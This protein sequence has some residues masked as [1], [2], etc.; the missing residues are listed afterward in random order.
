MA[1][2][3]TTALGDD[4]DDTLERA[5]HQALTEFYERHLPVLG[6]TTIVLLPIRNEGNA[7][8]SERVTAIGDPESPT[9][10]AGWA[11]TARYTQHVSSLLQEVTVTGAHPRLCL[12]ECTNQVKAK[13]HV[14]KDIQKGN[15]ELL[16][17]NTRLE[18]RIQELSDELM[19]TYRS[20]DIKMDN[21]DDTRTR[22]Q[23][24]QDELVAAQS[25][26]HHLKTE[27][28]ERDEELQASQAQAVDL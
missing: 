21:L 28:H 22:L 2:W 17:K 13:N 9:H 14:V 11:L 8:W 16:Q 23:H 18:T 20:R 24:A 1:A 27:L 3:F 10:H 19:R 5:A 12:E 6:D 25:Y 15:R 4:L 7:V 26:V